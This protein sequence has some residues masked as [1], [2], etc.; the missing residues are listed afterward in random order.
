MDHLI[1]HVG[2][3]PR[4]PRRTFL[5]A[6]AVGALGLT[7]AAF[8]RAQAAA[9]KSILV[10]Y[11]GGGVSHHDSFDPKP[12]AP[13]EVRGPFAVIPTR[14]PGVRFG[15][16]VPRLARHSERF[17]LIRSVHHTQTDHGVSAYYMLRGYVQ[18]DP[19]F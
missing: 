17:T 14:V 7:P 13:A 6:G 9:A 11:A 10:I 1:P 8:G 5:Q 4:L 2:R 15:E 3:P 16:L 18:P 19:T 12:G